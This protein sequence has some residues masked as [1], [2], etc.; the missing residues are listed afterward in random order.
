MAPGERSHGWVLT[1]AMRMPTTMPSWCRVPRAPR[2]SVGDTSPTY[3]GTKPV[4][5]P[6]HSEMR[7]NSTFCCQ[8]TPRPPVGETAP[9]PPPHTPGPA[10]SLCPQGFFLTFLSP[11]FK[12]STRGLELQWAMEAGGCRGFFLFVWPREMWDLSG[13]GIKPAS[14]ASPALAGRFFTCQHHL[15]SLPVSLTLYVMSK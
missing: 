2:S 1:W 13:P 10:P 7:Q 4:V 5:T 3:M 15:G 6:T 11:V 8:P 12:F 14:L 9:C